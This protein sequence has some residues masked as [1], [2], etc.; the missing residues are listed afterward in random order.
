MREHVR[1]HAHPPPPPLAFSLARPRVHA[2]ANA[3][4]ALTL[5]ATYFRASPALR[6]STY[7]ASATTA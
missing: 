7:V 6:T 4:L 3:C 5:R 2:C 1:G